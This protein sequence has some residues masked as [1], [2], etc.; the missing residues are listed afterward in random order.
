MV[1]LTGVVV[2]IARNL[3]NRVP[4][5]APRLVLRGFV[6]QLYGIKEAYAGGFESPVFLSDILV[7]LFSRGV[8]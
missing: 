8:H 2:L 7:S 5:K 4:S 1:S 3:A 6:D